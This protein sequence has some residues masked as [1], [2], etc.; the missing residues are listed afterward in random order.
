[1]A[2][3]C[4]VVWIRVAVDDVDDDDEEEEEEERLITKESLLLTKSAGIDDNRCKIRC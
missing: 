1:V 4:G 2:S 3:G